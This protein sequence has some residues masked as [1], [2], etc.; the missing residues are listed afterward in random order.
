MCVCVWICLCSDC[1]KASVNCL[2]NPIVCV[3]LINLLIAL[4]LAKGGTRWEWVGCLKIMLLVSNVFKTFKIE[5][6]EG[7]EFQL[8]HLILTVI[9]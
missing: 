9:K 5:K 3:G 6:L 4:Q 7:F 1:N 2:I 8:F